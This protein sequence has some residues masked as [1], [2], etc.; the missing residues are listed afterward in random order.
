MGI[1]RVDLNNWEIAIFIGY[2]LLTVAVGFLVSRGG[3]KSAKAYFI[4]DKTTA[5]VRDR[6]VHGGDGDQQRP[7]HRAGGRRLFARHRHRGLRMERVDRLLAADLGF[8]ALLHAHR[9]LHDAGVSGA[10]LQSRRALCVRHLLRDRLYR[11]ADRGAAVCGRTGAGKYVR[12]EPDLGHRAA[13]RADRRLHHL[14]RTQIRRLDGL[15]ADRRAAG[16]G[17]PGAGH[18]LVEGGRHLQAGRRSAAEISGLPSPARTSCFRGRE[19][20]PVS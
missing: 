14:R 9:P 1:G 8:S 17:N 3:R 5:L 4:G 12:H 19:S 16:R 13:G 18:R 11:F 15:H 6:H 10:P 2:L 7:F 20:S